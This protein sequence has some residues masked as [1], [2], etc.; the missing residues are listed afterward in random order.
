MARN[1]CLGW[2]VWELIVL[3]VGKQRTINSSAARSGAGRVKHTGFATA[4]PVRVFVLCNPAP[5]TAS[6]ASVSAACPLGAPHRSHFCCGTEIWCNRCWH[7]YISPCKC[8]CPT[9]CCYQYTDG[10]PYALFE[11]SSFSCQDFT[12]DDAIGDG[13]YGSTPAGALEW[14]VALGPY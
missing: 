5:S 1:R 9:C 12:G 3:A 8:C 2:V 13:K 11:R 7:T 6:L 10:V 14:A 4:S